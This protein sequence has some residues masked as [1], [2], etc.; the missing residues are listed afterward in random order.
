[1][2]QYHKWRPTHKC[3]Y[4]I[5]EVHG[6]AKSLEI[7]LRHILPLRKSN[8]QEDELIMLG[9]YIDKGPESKGVLDI[10]ISLKNEYGDKVILLRG[11]RE[12]MLLKSINDDDQ[13]KNWLN[14]MGSLTIRSYTGNDDYIP[15]TR[16][17]DVLPSSHIEFIKNM[18][19]KYIKGDYIFF[20]GSFD[21][22]KDISENIDDNF[23]YDYSA[24]RYVKECIKKDKD[25]NLIGGKIYIGA[26][27]YG[28]KEPCVFQNYFMLGGQEPKRLYVFELNSMC[29][30]A[31]K[32]NKSRIYKYNFKYYE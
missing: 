25:T 15:R 26:H 27:N 5:P 12:D 32:H 19:A 22:K 3:I 1:M 10:L 2:K 18:P 17:T 8:G 23:I 21:Y 6:N 9:D 28:G 13:Y 7:I 31:I 30:V 24:S 11:N 20:H 14:R 4:V 16:L 29:A